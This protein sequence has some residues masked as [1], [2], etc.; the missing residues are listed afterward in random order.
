MKRFLLLFAFT[1]TS[2]AQNVDYAKQIV[3]LWDTYCID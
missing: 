2:H 1:A 3:P